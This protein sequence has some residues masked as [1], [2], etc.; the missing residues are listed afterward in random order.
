[1]AAHEGDRSTEEADDRMHVHEAGGGDADGVLHGD[2]DHADPEE[3]QEP[4]AALGEHPRIGG[5]PDR[6]EEGQQQRVAQAQAEPEPDLED[7]VHHGQQQR[8]EA[9]ADDGC[10]DVEPREHGHAGHEEAAHEQD[11]ERHEQ[12]RD[13]VEL[14]RAHAGAPDRPASSVIGRSYSRLA[15]PIEPTGADRRAA[16]T[17]RA[18]F[19][20][21]QPSS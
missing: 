13:E 9:A 11:R 16:L 8:H 4:W 7:S 6:R 21:P 20:W 3:D 18:G 2:E 19:F 12:G 14:Y 15:P 5:E 1:V 10:R 17:P